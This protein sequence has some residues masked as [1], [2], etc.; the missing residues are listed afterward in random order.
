MLYFYF[1][2]RNINLIRF[3]DNE[4]LISVQLLLFTPS[5]IRFRNVFYHRKIMLMFLHLRMD[6]H[7][8]I[9]L[10]S[11][12]RERTRSAIYKK[13][14][15]KMWK[16]KKRS[17]NAKKSRRSRR[18]KNSKE[19]CIYV[20]DTPEKLYMLCKHNISVLRLI[21]PKRLKHTKIYNTHEIILFK[22]NTCA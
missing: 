10:D 7:S 13:W 1:F 12:R 5:V 22:R 16:K 9:L 8:K 15:Q 3:F 21:F 14:Y 6:F 4:N 17:Q 19:K 11:V 18:K 20:Y 2:F